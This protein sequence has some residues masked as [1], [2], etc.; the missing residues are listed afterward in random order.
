MEGQYY[1]QPRYGDRSWP[2]YIYTAA[3][4]YFL[5]F[6]PSSP[7]R[8]PL[9]HTTIRPQA[10]PSLLSLNASALLAAAHFAAPFASSPGFSPRESLTHALGLRHFPPEALLPCLAAHG[11]L[12]VVGDSNARNLASHLLESLGRARVPVV[13]VPWDEQRVDEAFSGPPATQTSIHFR[14]ARNAWPLLARATEDAVIG[15]GARVLVCHSAFWDMNYDTGVSDTDW[16]QAWQRKVARYLVWV[17]ETL[18]PAAAAADASRGGPPPPPLRLFFRDANPTAWDM[19]DEGRKRFMTTGRVHA[20]NAFLHAALAAEAA[21][22]G[23][24]AW[25]LLPTAP[26]MPLHQLREFVG[27]DGYHASEEVNGVLAQLLLND[28]CAPR[29]T[30]ETLRGLAEGELSPWAG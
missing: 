24:A 28:L 20:M 5:I 22:P 19:M 26:L 6:P 9:A 25:T 2:L 17:R 15:L 18:L 14:F 7:P 3:C 4:L 1:M 21:A 29:I 13:G 16:L 10:L 12:A 23:G 30:L 8:Q 11:P 27:D